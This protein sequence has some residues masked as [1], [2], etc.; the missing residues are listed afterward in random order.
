MNQIIRVVLIFG[1]YLCYSVNETVVFTP[2]Y[3]ET[4]YFDLTVNASLPTIPKNE[5]GSVVKNFDDYTVYP[6][7][8]GLKVRSLNSKL[9]S[10]LILTIFSCSGQIKYQV[11]IIPGGTETIVYTPSFL[12][13][14]IYFIE[15]KKGS[16]IKYTQ[17]LILLG[18]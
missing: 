8:K 15:I 3:G 10:E 1:C 5:L 12:K 9:S 11:N 13:L 6:V 17:K 14:G 18:L 16:I 7:K 4:E 2:G